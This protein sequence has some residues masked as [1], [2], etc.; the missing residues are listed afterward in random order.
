MLA[1]GDAGLENHSRWLAG[2]D[3]FCD[4]VQTPRRAERVFD[5]GRRLAGSGDPVTALDDTSLKELEGGC[6]DADVQNPV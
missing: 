1:G 3:P 4:L 6:A 5:I 2:T